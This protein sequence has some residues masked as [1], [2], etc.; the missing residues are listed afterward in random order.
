M[1]DAIRSTLYVWR[2]YNTTLVFEALQM[3][4]ELKIMILKTIL[5]ISLSRWLS[6]LLSTYSAHLPE[7]GHES[8]GGQLPNPAWDG[9]RDLTVCRVVSIAC[10]Q[11]IRRVMYLG[12]MS[13]AGLKGQLR[14][15][16]TA[17]VVYTAEHG[18]REPASPL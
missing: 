7:A 5:F 16:K 12:R 2:L 15:A 11:L 4:I 6:C 10:I 8:N 13:F 3:L 18:Q 1:R 17:L 9:I 14:L